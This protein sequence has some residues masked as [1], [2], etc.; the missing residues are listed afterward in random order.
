MLE[1]IP[2]GAALGAEIRGVDL[3]RSMDDE[4]FSLIEDA[5]NNHG[6]I[7]FRGQTITEKQ[8]I[9]FSKRF[10]ELE[11]NMNSDYALAD[12]PEVL[13]ISNVMENGAYIGLADAGTTWHT[14][15]SATATP[16][17]CSL[18]YSREVPFAADG[19]ALGDTLFTNAA[20]AY[21][22]LDES[23]RERL[24]GRMATHD[25]LA[26]MRAREKAVG[27]TRKITQAQLDRSPP[28]RHPVFRTHPVT[29]RK[30]IYVTE[31]EC[32]A[33]DDIDPEQSLE[34]IAELHAHLIKPTF[35]YRHNWRVGDLLMW[36][37]CTCQHVGIKDYALPQR[38]LMH[39]VTVNGAAPY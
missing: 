12:H 33:I 21:D 19:K 22:A 4:T 26:K 1:I 30:S 37:N 13:L 14:D 32:V 11:L 2:T 20:A 39:R 31:G 3:S 25:Y 16:P 24:E 7:F 10:G 17:R 29:G 5:F 35:H 6:V 18:L 36:D 8:Q 34:V 27:L 38:R 15:M 9:D 23:L 28:V